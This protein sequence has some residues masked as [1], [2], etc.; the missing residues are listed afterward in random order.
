[1]HRL[2]QNMATLPRFMPIRSLKILI[3]DEWTVDRKDLAISISLAS[4]TFCMRIQRTEDILRSC[5]HPNNRPSV[6]VDMNEGSERR[7]YM[8]RAG[9]G[10]LGLLQRF[11]SALH[12][13]F[14]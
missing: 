9:S 1:M 8:A 10:G 7:F 5:H 6:G 3:N 2:M 14:E 13:A 11:R 12:V 4:C